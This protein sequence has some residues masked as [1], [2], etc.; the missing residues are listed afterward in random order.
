M[1]HCRASDEDNFAALHSDPDVNA[2]LGGPFSR[3]KSDKKFKRYIQAQT[4]Q[5]YSRWV[6]ENKAGVFL[7]YAGIMPVI[8]QHPLGAHNEIGW[9]LNR[10]AWGHGYASEAARAALEDGLDRL[11]LTE[12]LSYTA[13]TN[14][15]SQSVMKR[16]G[17]VRDETR[18]FT[19]HYEGYGDWQGMVWALAA[20]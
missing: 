19:A 13:K 12:V 1:R 6:I 15:R 16:I 14:I 7:G 8:N 5:G 4:E 20:K 3:D 17:M 18:D 10:N 9:R 2:D 11:G